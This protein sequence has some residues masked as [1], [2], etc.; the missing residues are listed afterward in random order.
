MAGYDK[1]I[2]LWNLQGTLMK[3]LTGHGSW[4]YGINFSPDG[5]LLASASGDKTIKL[6]QLDGSL[7]L[8]LVGHNDWV[9]NVAFHPNNRQIASASADGKV[10]LWTLQLELKKLMRHGCDWAGLYLHNNIEVND[11]DR[12]LC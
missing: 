1:T 2:R 7:L 3:T 6:W 10:M 8:T 12:K 5:K 11:N 9:F 4:V